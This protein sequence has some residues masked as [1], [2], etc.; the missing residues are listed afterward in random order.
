MPRPRSVLCV[1]VV[2]ALSGAEA[3]RDLSRFTSGDKRGMILA[4]CDAFSHGAVGA[5]IDLGA[6]QTF[7]CNQVLASHGDMVAA[8][9]SAR[10][11]AAIT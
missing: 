2:E 4:L 9:F 7:S 6:A 3:I 11:F 10:I 5:V 1:A 8:Y